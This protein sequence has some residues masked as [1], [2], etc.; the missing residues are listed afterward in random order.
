VTRR[1]GWIVAAVLLLALMGT[2]ARIDVPALIGPHKGDEATFVAMALSLAHDADLEYTEADYTRFRAL[3]GR[4][5]E[6][7]FLRRGY[8]VSVEAQLAWPPVRIVREPV[9]VEQSLDYSKSFA[10]AV[11]AAP[12]VAAFGLGGILLMNTLLLVLVAVCS[13]AFARARCGPVSGTIV[14]VAF[15]GATV[16]PVYLIWLTPEVLNIALVGTGLFLW[17]YKEVAPATAW[18]GWRA[19][20]TDWLA[21]CLI[22]VATFS[23]PPNAVF[24]A[25]MVCLYLYRRQWRTGLVVA[26]MFLVGSAGNFGVNGLLT[27]EMNYQGGGA[28]R[29]SFYTNFPFDGTGYTFDSLTAAMATDGADADLHLAPNRLG[30]MLPSNIVYFFFGQYAGL[31]PFFFPGA[32][33]LVAFLWRWRQ[34]TLWQWLLL[35]ACGGGAL[36]LLVLTP[37]SWSGG[38]GP[39][40]NRYFLSLYPALL[41]LL[42][43]GFRLRT[44]ITS[45][46]AGL[47]CM[48]PVLARPVLMSQEPWHIGEHWPLRVL[49]VELTLLDDSPPRLLVSRRIPFRINSFVWMYYMDGNS[50]S[51]E[52]SSGVAGAPTDRFW[53]AGDRTARIGLRS[54]TPLTSVTITVW[55]R[56]PNQFTVE[57][58]GRGASLTLTA[59]Q[60]GT[61]RLIPGDPVYI[62]GSY[63]YEWSMT[64]T[65]GF[66]PSETDEG[67]A[68]TRSLGVLVTPVFEAE[69]ARPQAS[70]PS[71][72]SSSTPRP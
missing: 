63:A 65:S 41:F 71:S 11:A 8:D 56:V 20:W 62:G 45:A 61:I 7:V 44:A 22:G 6:G 30:A 3:F 53:I 12:F 52:P 35:L 51:P 15:W 60:H 42:P 2:S 39:V 21:A 23:K 64:T 58:Q 46:A 1:R 26:V 19:P 40:G 70:T 37:N 33:V 34:A 59:G 28:D 29:K 68:D 38:G 49:P 67:S 25:P 18:A 47:V 31:F 14:G 50:Y 13:V 54:N 5:P 4:G 24:I 16:V 55:S 43:A 17:L 10:F 48:A 57:M 9:P 66:V 69:A 32:A 36:V 72:T 27:G